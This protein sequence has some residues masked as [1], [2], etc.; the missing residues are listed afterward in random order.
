ML[1]ESSYSI[2]SMLKSEHSSSFL[3]LQS[4]ADLG[5]WPRMQGG[6]GCWR[7]SPL[8]WWPGQR[9]IMDHAGPLSQP[10]NTL[11][12]PWGNNVQKTRHLEKSWRASEASRCWQKPR[13]GWESA[14]E[15]R[16]SSAWQKPARSLVRGVRE[17]RLA[18]RKLRSRT[19]SQVKTR[20]QQNGKL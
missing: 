13:R 19:V 15:W 20:Q 16:A 4:D 17:R 7:R 1:C 3:A 10:W 8:N 11:K 9:C 14:S 5:Y 18:E 2:K 12:K 6:E